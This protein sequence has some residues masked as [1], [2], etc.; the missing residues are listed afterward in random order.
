MDIR[1]HIHTPRH[2]YIYPGG[3]GCCIEG[4][5]SYL[6]FFQTRPEPSTMGVGLSAYAGR[7]RDVRTFSFFS[8]RNTGHAACAVY[9]ITLRG[10]LNCI[11]RSE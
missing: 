5:T 9:G 11:H 7:T 8:I 1:A 6:H 3:C 10:L 2:I 4:C